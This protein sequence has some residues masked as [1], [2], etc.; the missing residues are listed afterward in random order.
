MTTQTPLLLLPHPMKRDSHFFFLMC[1][2]CKTDTFNL[3]LSL[4][5]ITLLISMHTVYS[6]FFSTSLWFPMMMNYDELFCD[7]PFLA[8]L[9][10]SSILPLPHIQL[11]SPT[12]PDI[13]FEYTHAFI[14]HTYFSVFIFAVHSSAIPPLFF[15]LLFDPS[16]SFRS[17]FS[18]MFFLF[19]LFVEF[20]V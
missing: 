11:H 18:Y 8:R 6:F 12:H 4:F 13:Q 3:F 9:F 2:Y 5:D 17:V 15:F 16:V 7:D 20:G 1:T 10:F 19:L 14:S